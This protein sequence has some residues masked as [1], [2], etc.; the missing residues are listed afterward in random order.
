MS[1]A[2]LPPISIIEGGCGDQEIW[3][4]GLAQARDLIAEGGS[5]RLAEITSN[6]L[7]ELRQPLHL[8]IAWPSGLAPEL[9]TTVEA[10]VSSELTA[11][12]V[13]YHVGATPILITAV[14][15]IACELMERMRTG[16]AAPVITE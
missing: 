10:Q 2:S 13:R 16:A 9:R 3:E 8:S 15:S 11:A 14:G 4:K 7:A 12:L 1:T 5:G 6:L